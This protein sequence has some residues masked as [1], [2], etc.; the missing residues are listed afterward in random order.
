M[1]GVFVAS[2]AIVIADTSSRTGASLAETGQAIPFLAAGIAIGVALLLRLGKS[3]LDA[4]DRAD[5]A[6]DDPAEPGD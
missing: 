6:S 1:D 3:R 2:L 5:E 4:A